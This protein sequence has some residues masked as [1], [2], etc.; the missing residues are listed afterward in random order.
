MTLRS[1]VTL[2][3]AIAILISAIELSTWVLGRA[4]PVVVPSASVSELSTPVPQTS[5][6]DDAP[7]PTTAPAL[8]W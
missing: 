1:V 2:L 3:L 8:T 5:E 7:P 6:V 4:K